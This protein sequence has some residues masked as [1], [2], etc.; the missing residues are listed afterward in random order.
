MGFSVRDAGI[1]RLRT[2]VQN[3]SDN[4]PHSLKDSLHCGEGR[5]EKG[6][7]RGKGGGQVWG[8]LDDVLSDHVAHAP[9]RLQVEPACDGIDVEHFTCEEKVFAYAAFEGVL[10]DGG[11]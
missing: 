5:T 9:G 2:K 4:S 6:E 8:S 11:E 1:G 10:V 3:H 7:K